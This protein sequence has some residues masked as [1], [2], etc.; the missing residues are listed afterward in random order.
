MKETRVE[1]LPKAEQAKVVLMEM[2]LQ[3][4]EGKDSLKRVE[5]VV[6]DLLQLLPWN[7]SRRDVE[8]VTKDVATY[9]IERLP[10]VMK[11]NEDGTP[12]EGE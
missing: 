12:S 11:E 1:D 8:A 6:S 10:A 5:H 7:L 2:M 9:G 3:C 4:A